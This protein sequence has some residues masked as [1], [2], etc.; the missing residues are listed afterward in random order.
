MNF[1]N[2][3]C[4]YLYFF[5]YNKNDKYDLQKWR[6][7]LHHPPQLQASNGQTDRMY[8]QMTYIIPVSLFKSKCQNSFCPVIVS[9][10]QHRYSQGI[11]VS[12]LPWLYISDILRK[13]FQKRSKFRGTRQLCKRLG[14]K[15]DV[16][17]CPFR[18][19]RHRTFLFCCYIILNPLL[20]IKRLLNYSNFSG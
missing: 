18:R 12:G 15:S 2:K 7:K 17:N 10:S 5:V 6:Y 3:R 1:R 8:V 20:P 13:N 16:C 11:S 4:C 9:D 19:F 14:I